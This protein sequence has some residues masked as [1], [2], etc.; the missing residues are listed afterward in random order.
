MLDF[1]ILLNTS[2]EILIV[3]KMNFLLLCLTYA[4][5]MIQMTQKDQLSKVNF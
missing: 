1:C 5:I 2:Q 3:L 4:L